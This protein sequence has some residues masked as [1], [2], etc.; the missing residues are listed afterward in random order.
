MSLRATRAG[1]DYLQLASGINE[2]TRT[3]QPLR[4]AAVFDML[5]LPEV[6]NYLAGARWCAENDDVWANMTLY[7]DTSATASGASFR[8]T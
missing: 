7:R 8:S 5:D 4:R 3:L 2:T 6:I 1:R